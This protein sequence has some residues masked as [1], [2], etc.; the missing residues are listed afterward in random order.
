[1][2]KIITKNSIYSQDM[3]RSY[4][5]DIYMLEKAM[6]RLKLPTPFIMFIKNLF[7]N[8]FNKIFTAHGITDAYKVLVGID[9][10]EVISPFLCCIYDNP[11]L[12]KIQSYAKE[13]LT[14]YQLTP[15]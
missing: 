14:G 13:N 11:L 8:Y 3:S 9:Q 12:R 2:L 7:T 15:K 10:G 5:R 6:I 4:D 1:M